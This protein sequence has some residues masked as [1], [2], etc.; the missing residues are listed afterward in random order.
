MHVSKKT[1]EVKVFE[2]G[3]DDEEGNERPEDDFF[4]FD[5]E[6]VEAGQEFMAVKPWIGAVKEPDN[7]PEVDKSQPD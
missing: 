7:H 6:E 1:G 3:G 4:E 5:A 2:A